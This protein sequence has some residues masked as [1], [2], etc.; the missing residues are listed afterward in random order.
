MMFKAANP[1]AAPAAFKPQ[2]AKHFRC[3]PECGSTADTALCCV[4]E[5]YTPARGRVTPAQVAVLA[6]LATG[7]TSQQIAAR[8]TV[9][10][11]TVR[12]HLRTLRAEWGART[13]TQ[14][15]AIAVRRGHISLERVGADTPPSP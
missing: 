15:V 3:C 8:L 13:R 1:Q 5:A 7:M 6:L 2:A 10:D 12:S 9:A 14:L 4:C 11:S